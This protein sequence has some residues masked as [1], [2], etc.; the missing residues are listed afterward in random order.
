MSKNGGNPKG[1]LFEDL[2]ESVTQMD[3]ILRGERAPSRE[4]RV[5]ALR[6]R[7]IRLSTGLSQARFARV[8]AVHVGTLRNWEQGMREPTGPARALLRAIHND[9]KH[10]LSALAH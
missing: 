7:D 4:F 6:V 8:L 2:L 10:V 9:P 3:E 5:D 1:K